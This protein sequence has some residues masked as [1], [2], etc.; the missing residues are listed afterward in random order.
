MYR[1]VLQTCP[2]LGLTGVVTGMATFPKITEEESLKGRGRVEGSTYV[3]GR[4]F[5]H[6]VQTN[7][8][9]YSQGL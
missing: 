6:R 2:R 5:R 9:F 4:I 7:D 1:Q 8:F 3:G